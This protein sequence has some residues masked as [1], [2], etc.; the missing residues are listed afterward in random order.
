MIKPPTSYFLPPTLHLTCAPEQLRTI[1][2]PAARGAAGG[3]REQNKKWRL[4]F[5]SEGAAEKQKTP[6][7]LGVFVSYRNI[8][9]KLC[10]LSVKMDNKYGILNNY[11]YFLCLSP[12][13]VGVFF[14]SARV[15]K[16]C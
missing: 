9:A 10:H 14:A 4:R 8:M 5:P 7:P 1:K 6:R 16:F 3:P 11:V 15:N 13:C 2:K 12:A